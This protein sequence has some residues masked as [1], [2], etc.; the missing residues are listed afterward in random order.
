MCFQYIPIVIAIVYGLI[1][2]NI[3]CVYNNG[4]FHYEQLN[5]IPLCC[6]VINKNKTLLNIN[7][8]YIAIGNSTKKTIAIYQQNINIYSFDCNTDKLL[9]I[10]TIPNAHL[11]QIKSLQFVT[12]YK[13]DSNSNLYLVSL[14][15]DT[16]NAL[17][18]WDVMNNSLINEFN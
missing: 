9:L 10:R 12:D 3:R 6:N 13:C 8:I 18:F 17:K 5:C 7:E 11:T 1:N 2:N 14:S 16:K 15:N 4:K